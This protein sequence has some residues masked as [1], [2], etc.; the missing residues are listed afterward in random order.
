MAEQTIMLNC[1][2]GMSTSLLVTKMQQ[3]AEEQGLDVKIFACPAS[4]ASQHLDQEEIDCV[5]L[6]PQVSYMKDDFANKVKGK[7]KDG[8]DIPLGVINMQA[9]GMMDGKKVLQQAQDLING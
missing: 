4:E 9:Y 6:G 3:A 1:S 5:L 7:G 8:K 2:A